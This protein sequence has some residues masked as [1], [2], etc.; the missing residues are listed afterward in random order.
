MSSSVPRQK[1]SPTL[2]PERDAWA[3]GFRALAGLDEAGRGPLA[4]PVVACAIWIDRDYLESSFTSDFCGL[5]DSKQ[6]SASRRLAWALDL[7]SNP[8]IRHGLGIASAQEIDRVNILRATHLAMRRALESL[9]GVDHALIDGLPVPGLPVPSTAIVRG[10]SASF[11]IAAASVLAKVWRD[12]ELNAMDHRYPGYGFARHK[13]YGTALHL[14]A[15]T[16]LG[17]T[18]EHRLSFAPVQAAAGRRAVRES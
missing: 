10:D 8:R 15:L 2:Q 7:R 16:R 1:P 4:G 11:S 6:L 9:N 18:P 17:P 3:R 13:G 14:E 5:T 12:Q